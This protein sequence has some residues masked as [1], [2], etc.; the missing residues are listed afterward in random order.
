[1]LV[2]P[3]GLTYV[4][5]GVGNNSTSGALSSITSQDIGG[6]GAYT[7]TSTITGGT[8]TSANA[9]AGIQ[10]GAWT[11]YTG[12]SD[13][14]SQSL[15]GKNGGAPSSWMYGPQGYVDASNGTLFA[16]TSAGTFTYHQDGATA[17]ISRNTGLTGTL[18]SASFIVNFASML[19]SGNMTLTM[20]GNENWGAA[21]T[22]APIVLGSPLN[23]APMVTYSVG[24][25]VPLATCST[26]SGN[27]SGMFTG[28]NLAGAILSYD[29][30]N[31]AAMGGGDVSGNVALTRV[32][33]SGNPSVT[34]G[35]AVTPTNI[36]VAVAGQNGSVSTYP[37]TSS[38]INTTNGLLTA[39][40]SSY[41]STGYSSSYFTTVTCITCTST[42]SGDL[43]NSGIYYGNWSEGTYAQAISST[44]PS[45]TLPAYW[46]T[47]PEA[48][49]LYLPQA[50]TGTASYTFNAG[51]VSNSLGAAGTF[52]STTLS[53][54]FNKQTVGI[55]L[56]VTVPDTLG[57]SHTWNAKTLLGNEAVL[58][59]GQG[60]SGAAFSAS[61]FNNG[62]GSGLLTVVVGGLT[63]NV[64]NPSGY[65]NGQLT[66]S[67][68]TGAIMSFNL[69]GILNAATATTYEN[70]NGVAAFTGTAANIATPYQ[71]VS[72][73]LADP[74]STVPQPVL[75]FYA[76]AVSATTPTVGVKTDGSGNLTQFDTQIINN[77]GNGSSSTVTNVSAAIADHG[78]DPVSGISWGRWAGGTFNVTDR[79][80]RAATLVTQTG[81]L[82][83]ITAP[84]STTAVTLP[85][86]GTYTYT[87]AGG[88][89]P[90]D[91]LGSVG[92]L[93]SATLSANFTAQTVNVGVNATVAGATLNAAGN[94]VP[95]IQQTVFYA[96]SQEPAASTSHLAVTCTGTCG[97]TLGGTVIG[98]FTGAGAIGAAMTYGLQNGATTISGVT[99]FHR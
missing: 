93:N 19:L 61:T 30:Y 86:T 26:C 6:G 39:Y 8:P 67:G 75:G 55:N 91:N 21:V 97:A 80:T 13:T 27:V 33:V 63:N 12:L 35:A 52:G 92:T 58:G 49:P 73:A 82:H 4:A 20:P 17:P 90:T 74:F 34:N 76:N 22:N 94:S 42:A 54:D 15:G 7:S 25:A 3:A 68:L 71:Y 2:A 70:I 16:G 56:I 59:N 96:S 48:G 89:S 69:G 47:G 45:G 85:T 23:V 46:I 79:A 57:T 65:I 40:G 5:G 41:A 77:N 9:S 53:L 72:I 36:A 84:V 99:A 98:K 81:S 18:T 95:I 44:F 60:N 43:V 14:W 78:T 51:Q 50:L 88:T 66:G 37:V 11:G 1:M 10:Y 32:G 29:L 87:N 62:V 83:W 31:N 28:Q 24:A 38:T 64:T